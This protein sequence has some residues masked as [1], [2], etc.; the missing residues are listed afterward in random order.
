MFVRRFFPYVLGVPVLI[1]ASLL[2]ATP[3]SATVIPL[4]DLALT[5]SDAPDPV[6]SPGTLTYT[7]GVTNQGPG[8]ATGVTVIDTLPGSVI[9]VSATPSQGSCVSGPTAITCTLGTLAGGAGATVVLVVQTSAASPPTIFNTATVTG[10]GIDLNPANNIATATTTVT[11]TPTPG[12]TITGTPGNDNLGGTSGNDVICG[13]GGND[14]ISGG[15]GNDVLSGGEGNDA[16]SG[17]SGNDVQSGG[18]GDDVLSGGSGND[19]LT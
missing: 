13:L 9:L 8:T 15:S 10:A 1:A 11:T 12:C 16:L 19:A 5:K 17:G 14:S 7:L 3:A 2:S 6:S 4:T 18:S